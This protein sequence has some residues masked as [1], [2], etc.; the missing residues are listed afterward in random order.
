MSEETGYDLDSTLPAS[1]DIEEMLVGRLTARQL[2]ALCIGGG[3]AYNVIFKIPNHAIGWTLGAIILIATY[4]L[5]FYKMR[6]YDRYLLE[7]LYY[8]IKFREEQQ[9]FI[10]K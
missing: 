4:F 5:G 1:I 3:I 10:N 6:K 9:I 7:H 2:T 8:Y